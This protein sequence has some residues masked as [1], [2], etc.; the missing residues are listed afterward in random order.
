[1]WWRYVLLVGMVA[2]PTGA[3]GAEVY[4]WVDEN[5]KVHFSDRPPGEAAQSSE[6]VETRTPSGESAEAPSDAER[7]KLRERLLEE[8][9]R[10]REEK[11][12]TKREQRAA[13][14]ELARRCS[15]AREALQQIVDAT[16][17]FDEDESGERLIYSDEQREAATRELKQKIR[18]HCG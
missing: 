11:A 14:V 9:D 17:L 4:K 13:K 10:Q 7:R 18:K 3:G 12:K 2:L 5:G 16:Y 8:F 1:M 6:T 15:L